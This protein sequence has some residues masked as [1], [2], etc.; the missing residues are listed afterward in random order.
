MKKLISTLPLLVL[1]LSLT[2]F[3][4]GCKSDEVITPADENTDKESISLSNISTLS[5]IITDASSYAIILANGTVPS[6]SGNCPGIG[7]DTSKKILQ[8]S[9][10]QPPGCV[11]TINGIRRSGELNI[12]YSI[13]STGDTIE[14]AILFPDFRT[15]KSSA[16]GDTNLI[17]INGSIYFS[18]KKTGTGIYSFK[19]HGEVFCFNQTDFI[20]EIYLDSLSGTVNVNS[21]SSI[22]DDAYTLRGG[23]RIKDNEFNISYNCIISAGTSLQYVSNCRFPLTGVIKIGNT[24]CDFSPE[25]SSCDAIVRLTKGATSKTID[26]TQINF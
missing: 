6:G 3:H 22:N 11:S 12:G 1:V 26:L 4:P 19:S 10:P 16:L 18:L 2:F 9:Y 5:K 8:I 21:I 15:Y 7:I 17:K 13:S 24:N 23:A 25:A 14:C 20:K